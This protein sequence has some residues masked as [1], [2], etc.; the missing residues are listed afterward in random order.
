MYPLENAD[1]SLNTDFE[2]PQNREEVKEE[3]LESPDNKNMQLIP[4]QVNP[5][6]KRILE[7]I[8]RF[9]KR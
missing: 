9:F 7:C 1:N 8:K 4:K 2:I 6:Y 5:W 3:V